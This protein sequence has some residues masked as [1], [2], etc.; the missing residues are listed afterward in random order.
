MLFN[1]FEFIFIFSP[2]TFLLWTFL[3]RYCL[4]DVAVFALLLASMFFYAY[5]N[6]P[7][8]LLLLGSVIVNYVLQRVIYSYP[9]KNGSFQQ[10]KLHC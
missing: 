8:I 2:C 5:W 6:L 9:Q 7:F 10:K 3:R 1:S 4:S